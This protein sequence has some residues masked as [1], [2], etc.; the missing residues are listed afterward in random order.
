MN[1]PKGP[2]HLCVRVDHDARLWVTACGLSVTAAP[3]RLQ[4][5]DNVVGVSTATARRPRGTTIPRRGERVPATVP[6]HH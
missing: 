5:C 6:R 2:A 3:Q 1:T 4:D